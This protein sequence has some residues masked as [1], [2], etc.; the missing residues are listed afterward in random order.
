MDKCS[1]NGKH[2]CEKCVHDDG[3]EISRLHAE[4]ER[5]KSALVTEVTELKGRLIPLESQLATAQATIDKLPKCWRLNEA[6]ELVQDCPV[7]PGMELHTPDGGLVT[8]CWVSK[9]GAAFLDGVVVYGEWSVDNKF[10]TP[11]A[12]REA[13]DAK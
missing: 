10:S 11:E 7:V 4:V 1:C 6:G 12:A 9:N 13:S 2:W 8:A 3:V 5:L